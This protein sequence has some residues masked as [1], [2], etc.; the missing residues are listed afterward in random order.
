MWY[1]SSEENFDPRPSE[2]ESRREYRQFIRICQDL[3]NEIKFLND[4]TG[5]RGSILKENLMKV[6]KYLFCKSLEYN[7]KNVTKNTTS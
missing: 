1:S 6:M 4:R 3:V 5:C 7:V 2:I